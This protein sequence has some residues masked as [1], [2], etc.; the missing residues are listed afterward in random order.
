MY[1]RSRGV[2]PGVTWKKSSWCLGW[3]LS[4]GSPDFESGALTTRLRCPRPSLLSLSMRAAYNMRNKTACSVGISCN[5]DNAEKF[6]VLLNPDFF[7]FFFT[8]I[9]FRYCPDY[10]LRKRF[11]PRVFPLGVVAFQSKEVGRLFGP[12]TTI[13]ENES[14]FLCAVIL[15]FHSLTRQA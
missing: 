5:E 15:G 9:K 4:S 14:S 13:Q 1:K 2:E 3:D 7:F 10:S 12:W 8:K 6:K 11:W